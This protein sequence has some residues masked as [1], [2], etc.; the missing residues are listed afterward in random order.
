MFTSDRYAMPSKGPSLRT[1][2]FGVVLALAGLVAP[3][4]AADVLTFQDAL[5]IAAQRSQKLVARDAAASA[6]RDMAVAASRLPDPTLKLGLNNLPVNGPDAWSVTSDFMTMRSIALS[7]EFTREGKRKARADRFEREAD[8]VEASRALALTTLQRDT[9]LAW[10]DRYFQ[11]RLRET[12][13]AQRDEARLQVE[14][15]DAGYRGGRGS[16]ADVFASRSSVALIEDR[17]AQ[18]DRQIAIATSQLARWVGTS[19]QERLA[20]PP[21]MTAVGLMPADLDTQLAHHPQITVMTKQEEVARAE[22][23]MAQANRQADWNVE[24]MYSQ[25]GPAYSNMVSLNVSVPLQ[26]DRPARQDRELAAK[27]ALADELRA[28]REDATRAHVAEVS[29][30]LVEWHSDRE[31]LE[32]YENT[33]IPLATE[34]TRAAIAAYRGGGGRLDAVLEARRGEIDARADQIRLELEAARIWAQ[35]NFLIPAGAPG[36]LP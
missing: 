27:L 24:L 32:R 16:Q 1:G 8:V 18:V 33:L 28:E 3:A 25:R 29:A 17:I 13:I 14:A 6:A 12:L 7:Q 9:A 2:A 19:A 36:L 30:M 11:E 34:R 15:A 26:W 23:Q 10:L 35:L 5:R 31:R 20:A 4:A 22:V 21:L